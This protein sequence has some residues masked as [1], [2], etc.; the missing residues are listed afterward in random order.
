MV[1]LETPSPSLLIPSFIQTNAHSHDNSHIDIRRHS[2]GVRLLA[3]DQ[4]TSIE[5]L[6]LYGGNGLLGS[7]VRDV[8]RSIKEVSLHEQ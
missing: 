3:A 5:E 1:Q 2:H 6:T 4:L 7:L 8:R